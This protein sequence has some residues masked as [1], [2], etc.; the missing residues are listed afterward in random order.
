MTLTATTNP[1]PALPEELA[2]EHRNGSVL[3]RAALVIEA[4]RGTT[5]GLSLNEL[6]LRTRLAKS[7]VYRIAESL[8]ELGW[9]ERDV[10]GYAIGIRLFEFGELAQR[11]SRIRESAQPYLHRLSAATGCAA[12]LGVLDGGEVLYLGKVSPPNLSVPTRIGARMPARSTALGKIMLAFSDGDQA[13]DTPDEQ[14]R[15]ATPVQLR[16]DLAHARLEQ[17][18]FDHEESYPGIV[19]AA[20][21]VRGS[22]RAVAA[23]SVTGRALGFDF[24]KAARLARSAAQATWTALFLPR[25]VKSAG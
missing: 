14:V 6:I 23:I 19:C 17:I 4:F 16:D 7:T 13:G 10:R 11:P 12:H 22:G 15:A 20:A 1:D 25:S 21:A 3:G 2:W 5:T 24:P 9:L 18:A 8:V